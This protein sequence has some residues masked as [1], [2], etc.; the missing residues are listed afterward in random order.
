VALLVGESFSIP[1]EIKIDGEQYS[2]ISK[3]Y[4]PSQLWK[5]EES[6]EVESNLVE[7]EYSTSAK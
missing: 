3:T 2:E 4:L 5:R 6:V 7:T 1:L